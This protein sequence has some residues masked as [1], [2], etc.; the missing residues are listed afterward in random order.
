MTAGIISY[1][2]I[3]ARRAHLEHP[4]G[5]ECYNRAVGFSTN[6]RVCVCVCKVCS[7]YHTYSFS[8]GERMDCCEGG[9]HRG[10]DSHMIPC[11][12]LSYDMI[13][14]ISHNARFGAQ[15]YFGL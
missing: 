8:G 1:H 9:Y 7:T 14:Y 5:A 15:F 4:R 3:L 11:T 12:H 6:L 10:R 13:R 2:I